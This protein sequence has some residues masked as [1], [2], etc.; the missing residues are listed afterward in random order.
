[1]MTIRCRIIYIIIIIIIILI[2]NN[3]LFSGVELGYK[4]VDINSGN[5]VRNVRWNRGGALCEWE[6]WKGSVGGYA[7]VALV[8]LWILSW[9]VCS[10]GGVWE[11]GCYTY[12]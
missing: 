5:N 3:S 9:V 1:M 4:E 6:G 2:F 10:V 8:V 11:M 7:V 12:S